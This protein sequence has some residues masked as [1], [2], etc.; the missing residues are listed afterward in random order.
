MW[1][2]PTPALILD[3]DAMS[4]NLDRF[5]S[6]YRNRAVQVRPHAK[7]HKS[8][9]IARA[10]L[11]RGAAG[12]CVAKLSE[13]EMMIGAGI[14]DILVTTGIVDPLR[15]RRLV[16]LAGTHP[17]L[18][19][20]TDHAANVD[21]LASAAATAGVTL[22]VLVD[23]NCGSNRT[24]AA[25]GAP[26]VA[27]AAHVARK[28]SLRLEGFQ[29]FASHVMHMPGY[30]ERRSAN[31]KALDGAVTTRRKAERAGLHVPVLSVGGT[32]TWD[33]DCEVEGVTEV[34]AGSYVFMDAMYR[35]IGGRNG[36]V[37]D[38]FEPALFVLTT[39]ISQPVPGEITVDAGYKASATDHQPPEPWGIGDVRYRWAGDEH[40]ILRLIHPSR[41]VKI[42]DRIL[43]V[44]SHCDPTVNLYDSYW[45]C[46][47]ERVV[48]QWPVTG[49]GMSQ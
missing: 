23:L 2:L 29:A 15:I 10:Q 47:G 7:T 25:T 30:H 14:T 11:A 18:R 16:A 35:A 8:P 31:L 21:L 36:P 27:L 19:A 32:G 3:L 5:A 22:G 20:V 38:D 12:I 4:R 46:S 26:A 49:R 43:M 28:S 39:A 48:A 33:I 17:T 24:G 1:D 37:F 44:A 34:Q 45:V 42:G 41:P 13:A 6:H 40:G 9:V